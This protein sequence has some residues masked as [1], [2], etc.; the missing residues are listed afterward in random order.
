VGLYTEQF[1]AI[2]PFADL[3]SYSCC[4]YSVSLVMHI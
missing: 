4:I 2:I 1:Y 3:L